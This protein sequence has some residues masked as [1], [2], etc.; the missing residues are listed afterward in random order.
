MLSQ[1]LFNQRLQSPRMRPHEARDFT[2]VI[3]EDQ[4]GNGA[5]VQACHNFPVLTGVQPGKIQPASK[6][7]AEPMIEGSQ[8]SEQSVSE[9][10]QTL[11]RSKVAEVNALL[12]HAQAMKRMLEQ[13]LDCRCPDLQECLNCLR[14]N[15]QDYDPFSIF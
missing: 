14:A 10:W 1:H 7:P 3:E 11:A 2:T 5:D 9:R 15:Y 4:R 6:L 8:H 12:Q 13:G